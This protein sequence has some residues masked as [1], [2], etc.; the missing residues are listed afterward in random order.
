MD[1]RRADRKQLFDIGIAGAAGRIGADN[2]CD[3]FAAGFGYAKPLPPRGDEDPGALVSI[4]AHTVSASADDAQSF[5]F[6]QPLAVTLFRQWL[7]PDIS[8]DMDLAPNALYIA[9]W[10]GLLITGLNMMP[11]SQLDGGHVTYGLFGRDSRFI[12][13]AVIVLAI[14]FIVVTGGYMWM[15]MVLLVIFLGV[16][17]PRTADDRA[18]IGPFRW[19]MGFTSLVIPILCFAP[20]PLLMN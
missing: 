10:F 17:H 11:V 1:G 14:A 15:T 9:G 6:G 5:R 4:S 8:P 19:A 18:R 12:G 16:D 7:R 2:T 3:P 20:V 13:R